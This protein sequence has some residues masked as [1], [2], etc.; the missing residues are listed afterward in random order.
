[1]TADCVEHKRPLHTTPL[2]PKS[3]SPIT[4]K[5]ND[6]GDITQDAG[7][8]PLWEMHQKQRALLMD[9]PDHGQRRSHY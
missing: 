1:M 7:H 4:N 2:S 8:Q 3:S 9:E 5:Q 6:D